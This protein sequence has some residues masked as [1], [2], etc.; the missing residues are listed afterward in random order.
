MDDAIGE[1]FKGPSTKYVK[2]KQTG[3][4]AVPG[5]PDPLKEP[6]DMVTV[7]SPC[8]WYEPVKVPAEHTGPLYCL[9]CGTAFAV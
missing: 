1:V 9:I 8:H 7:A 5:H 2:F 4:L 3:H 6:D